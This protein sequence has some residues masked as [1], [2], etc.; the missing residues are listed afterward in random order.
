M[1]PD[2]WFGAGLLIIAVVWFVL[3]VLYERRVMRRR[4]S[5]PL[6]RRRP[7]PVIDHIPLEVADLIALDAELRG[8]SRLD[9]LDGLDTRRPD[10]PEPKRRTPTRL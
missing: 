4:L 10:P 5:R 7:A 1:N 3:G 8:Y 2:R 6:G 9:R